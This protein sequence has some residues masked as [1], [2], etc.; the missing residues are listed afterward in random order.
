[1]IV[2]DA[3]T[4]VNYN[5]KAFREAQITEEFL[6]ARLEELKWAAVVQLL[7]HEE[8]EEQRRL[9]EQVREEE[10]AKREFERA[11]KESAREEDAL[12]KAMARAEMEIAVATAEQKAKFEEQLRELTAKLQEAEDRNK[13][14]ISMAQQTKKGNVYVISNLGSFGE[15]VFKIG[16]TRRLEPLDRIRELGDSSVPFEFD[17]HA[18]IMCDDAPALER[19]LHRHFVLRQVNK[20]NHRKEF[21]RA[22]L[23]EIRKEIE[24]LGL[25]CK[26]T[27]AAEAREYRESLSI[28]RAIKGDPIARQA[29]VN[30]QLT[31]ESVESANGTLETE[32]EEAAIA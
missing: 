14:A 10:K 16:L 21:F 3:F 22:P 7:K 18:L 13:R 8:Q 25:E 12:R 26:W 20:V 1:V 4:L 23:V 2:R 27:M 24:S 17:V 30:R 11:I 15:N 31:L 32:T 29:W 6:T 28:E 9:R 19:K 5:G